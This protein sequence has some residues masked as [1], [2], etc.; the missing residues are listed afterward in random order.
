VL[1]LLALSF[2]S[3][4]PPP[5]AAILL[6]T[7]GEADANTA[8]R[9]ERDLRN[10][11]DYAHGEGEPV[12]KTI[13]IELRYD[14][15]YISKGELQKSRRHF[16]E[17]QRALEKENSDEAMG[18]LFRAQR[19]YN[20][21]I[22]YAS[23]PALL[24]GIFFY[25]YLAHSKAGKKKKA[26]NAYCEYVSI[27]RNLAGSVGSIDQFEP[28]A[29]RCGKTTIAGTG[30]L[31]LRANVDGAHVYVDN[32]P[33]GI[34]GKQLPYGAPFSSA[35]P[36]LVEVRK[37]GYA[38]WGKL[39]T[40]H[41]GESISLQA[42]LKK[43]R[44]RK[45]DYDTL[46]QLSFEGSEAFS[47][48]YIADLFFQMAERFRVSE[49]VAAYLKK[50]QKGFKLTIFSY[51]DAGLERREFSFSRQVDA[52]HPALSQFWKAHFG[53]S[54]NPVD[55]LPELDRWAPTLFKVE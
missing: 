28:L 19:F 6:F 41:R 13:P 25:Y 45:K 1:P 47:E 17:A 53:K 11:Y 36:H 16:N 12:P 18:Q 22:P 8:V 55:A 3:A 44:N 33:V 23:D 39:I 35:G 40:L 31:K 34:I 43:A 42:R 7:Q 51:G 2:L 49:L 52:H 48:S 27:T 32:R 10:M 46:A 54:L 24:R 21:A 37:A 4:E 20:K 15:G 38:R 30:E 14:V 5:R 29:E 26:L 50:K 9:I